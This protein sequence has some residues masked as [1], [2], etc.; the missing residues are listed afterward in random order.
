MRGVSTWLLCLPRKVSRKISDTTHAVKVTAVLVSRRQ[1]V[2]TALFWV[3]T[4][5]VVVIPYRRFGTTYRSHP[6]GSRNQKSRT[7]QKISYEGNVYDTHVIW[8]PNEIPVGWFPWLGSPLSLGI[9]IVEVSRSHSDTPHSIELLWMSAQPLAE[10]ST[11]QHTTF[12]KDKDPCPRR[13][14]NPQS[15]QANGRRHT[16]QT[17]RPLR[18]AVRWFVFRNW[19]ATCCHNTSR[20]VTSRHVMSRHVMSR[21]VMSLKRWMCSGLPFGL[22]VAEQQ[23]A[24]T[25]VNLSKK[26][27]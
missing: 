19:T 13:D 16:P 12:T 27:S 7:G 25:A 26:G 15:Q 14:S 17:A 8:A 2:K 5:Q 20:H 18:S 11:W 6:Q 22:T 21:R 23:K 3:I 10:T 9:R 1:K 24:S 4:Q